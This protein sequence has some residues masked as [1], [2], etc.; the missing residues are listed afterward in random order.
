MTSAKTTKSRLEG[1]ESAAAS[2]TAAGSSSSSAVR[3]LIVDDHPIV[4]RGV[5]ETLVEAFPG[6]IIGEAS[7]SNEGM[8]RVWKDRWDVAVLDVSM[9]GRSGLEILKVIKQSQPKLPVLIMSVHPEDQFA[10]RVLQNGAAGYLTKSALG[11]ELV[12]AVKKL[13]EGGRY[14]RPSVAEKLASHVGRD[15]AKP[16]HELLS[17]R[18]FE[19]LCLIASGKTVKEIGAELS[20]SIKTI[21]TYRSRILEKMDLRNN[22]ELM[23]YAVEQKLVQF[24]CAEVH[25][26]H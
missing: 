8:E 1:I 19:V 22:A 13:L 2:E 24:D 3:I 4:R 23:R 6:A 18:E 15:S 25:S 7:D 10:V 5:K 11:T 9:P 16:L 21:S 14:I 12:T 26:D 20:L 17:D